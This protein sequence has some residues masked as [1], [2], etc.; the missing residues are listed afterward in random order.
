MTRKALLAAL[1]FSCA[2]CSWTDMSNYDATVKTNQQT[3]EINNKHGALLTIKQP[4]GTEIV[5]DDRG[6]PEGQGIFGQLVDYATV[7]AASETTE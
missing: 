7:R 4:D 6:L 1:I 2:G 5:A 3:Y